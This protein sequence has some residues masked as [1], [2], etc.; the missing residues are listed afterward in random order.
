MLAFTALHSGCKRI[1]SESNARRVALL[2]EFQQL[3]MQ[4]RDLESSGDDLK[5]TH[6]PL[7][8]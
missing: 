4:M 5:R 2:E 8:L 1:C 6:H 3:S 7:R